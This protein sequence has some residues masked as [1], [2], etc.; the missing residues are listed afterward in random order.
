MRAAE[1]W[2]KD[3]PR[4]LKA[5]VLCRFNND[6]C[7]LFSK[8]YFQPKGIIKWKLTFDYENGDID[9]GNVKT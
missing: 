4:N 6:V 1:L 7:S 3:M 8:Q 5:V 9:S 2:N